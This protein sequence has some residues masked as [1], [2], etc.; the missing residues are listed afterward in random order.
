M[1]Q[2]TFKEYIIAIHIFHKRG[3]FYW[4]GSLATLNSHVKWFNDVPRAMQAFNLTLIKDSIFNEIKIPENIERFLFD[5]GHSKFVECNNALAKTNSRVNKTYVQNVTKNELL[6]PCMSNLALTLESMYKHY[7]LSSGTLL[8][9][10]NND[11]LIK[12]ILT[13]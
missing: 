13:E 12:I 9:M 7:W 6:I 8:G 3:S 11:L 5:Y 4:I 2:L 10:S 1:I